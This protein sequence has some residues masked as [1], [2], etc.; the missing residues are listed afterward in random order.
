MKRF[1]FLFSLLLVLML[2]GLSFAQDLAPED[3]VAN[4]TERSSTIT[5]ASFVVT[6]KLIDTDTQEIP[7]EVNVSLI[8]EG[9]IV[10]ADFLQ[11]DAMADNFM[12][13]DGETVSNYVYLTNQVSVFNLGD[14]EALA[15]LFPEREE[16]FN[17]TLDVAQL[18]AGW[19][20]AGQGYENNAYT[21]R[22][23]N[24]ASDEPSVAYVDV[25]VEDQTWLPQ[26][27]K[28]Y[29]SD[30][31]VFADIALVDIKL[32]QG[33]NPEDVRY[34]DPSAEVIDER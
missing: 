19:D 31:I 25:T 28:F 33:L 24:I 23:T 17:F 32:D 30:N 5:D 3:V 22:F 15:G 14:P 21:L 9:N 20:V 8:T 12:L 11:P 18:F 4:M 16:P 26:T 27:M 6:G 10:R 2:L 29:G 34:L 7:L 13:I 1:V